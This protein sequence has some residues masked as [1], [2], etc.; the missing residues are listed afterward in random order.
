MFHWQVWRANC[1]G[2]SN[3][4]NLNG[5]LHPAIVSTIHAVT[6][7]DTHAVGCSQI[8]AQYRWNVQIGRVPTI[9]C[10]YP[11]WST[12]TMAVYATAHWISAYPK[13]PRHSKTKGLSTSTSPLQPQLQHLQAPQ[14]WSPWQVTLSSLHRANDRPLKAEK[15][16]LAGHGMARHIKLAGTERSHK[17]DLAEKLGMLQGISYSW[18]PCRILWIL[19]GRWMDRWW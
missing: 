5:H 7:S 8:A 14:R 11:I 9:I 18:L 3:L 4:S 1:W 12:A 15:Q 6:C 17:S 13:I 2:W 10:N 16:R 19:W